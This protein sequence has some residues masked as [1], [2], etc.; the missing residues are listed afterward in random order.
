LFNYPRDMC[1]RNTNEFSTAKFI[2]GSYDTVVVIWQLKLIEIARE[3]R[4]VC[5]HGF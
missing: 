3:H 4:E 1:V 5:G 2:S